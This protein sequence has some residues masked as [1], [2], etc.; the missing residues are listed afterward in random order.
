MEWVKAWV[1]TLAE[2]QAYVRE[3]HTTGLNWNLKGGDAITIA[4]SDLSQPSTV[5]PP[6]PPG[7]PAPPPPPPPVS[8]EAQP[9]ARSTLLDSLNK[10]EDITKGLKKVSD[11]DKTHKNPELRASST[12]PSNQKP[13]VESQTVSG[14]SPVHELDGK[15]WNIENIDGNSC[16]SVET[17]GTNQSVY[18]YR[19]NGSTFQVSVSYFTQFRG[20]TNY[21]KSINLIYVSGKVQQHNYGQLQEVRCCF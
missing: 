1:E 17:S 15:K 5:S 14:R 19:C 7:P 21:R 3:H 16:V 2:L 6:P 11:N 8:V 20:E 10:G 13:K 12:V 18:I 9:T 4:K